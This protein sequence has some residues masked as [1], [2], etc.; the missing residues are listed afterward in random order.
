[1]NLVETSVLKDESVALTMKMFRAI[2]ISGEK[3]TKDHP[4]ADQLGGNKLPRLV[5]VSR[6]GN[7]VGKIEGRMAPNTLFALMK[8]A[9]A[10]DYLTNVDKMV[11]DA[12]TFLTSLD[13]IENGLKAL[14]T[15]EDSELRKSSKLTPTVEAQFAKEREALLADQQKLLEQE[16]PL[17]AFELKDSKSVATVAK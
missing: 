8:K 9:A 13:K 16:K 6:D 4:L 3:I 1:M 7:V 11:K 15:K 12:K 5:F 2:K 10:V 17:F 14:K